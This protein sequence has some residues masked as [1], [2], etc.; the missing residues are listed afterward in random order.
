M[1]IPTLQELKNSIRYDFKKQEF[2]LEK[3]IFL[4]VFG[5]DIILPKGLYTDGASF[6][7]FIDIFVKGTDKDVMI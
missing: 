7:F 5:M 2:V 6:P 1:K 4:R 3:D